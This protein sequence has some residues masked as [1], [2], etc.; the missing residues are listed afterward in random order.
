MP[1]PGLSPAAA[2]PAGSW[3][4][5]PGSDRDRL[6]ADAHIVLSNIGAPMSPAKVRRLVIAF[7][8]RVERNGFSFFEFLA[9]SVALSADERRAAL[10]NPDIARVIAY[11]DPTGEEA[12]ANVMRSARCG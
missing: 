6:I 2:R 11:R 8:R 10:S 5:G 12:V 3:N 4:S 7:E 9:N 1:P